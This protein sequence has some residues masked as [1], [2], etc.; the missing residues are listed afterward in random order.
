MVSAIL[1]QS[2]IIL[3]IVTD[4]AHEMLQEPLI[5]FDTAGHS[6]FEKT[7]AEGDALD[8]GSKCNENEASIVVRWVNKLVG[9]KC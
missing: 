3:T 4:S 8:E 9:L 5:F 6:F 7:E 1:T 2:G